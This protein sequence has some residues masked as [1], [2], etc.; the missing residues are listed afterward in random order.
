MMSLFY[1]ANS[2]WS[3]FSPQADQGAVKSR[4]APVIL[5]LPL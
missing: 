2:Q 5:R 3:R 4:A 1:V